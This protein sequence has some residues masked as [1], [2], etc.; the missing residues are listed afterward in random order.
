MTFTIGQTVTVSLDN[1]KSGLY[2]SYTDMANTLGLTK[3]TEGAAPKGYGT[4]VTATVSGQV[5]AVGKHPGCKDE[6]EKIICELLTGSAEHP[7]AGKDILGVEI[8]GA[9]FLYSGEDVITA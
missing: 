5:V 2:T 7:E 6:M 3:Y 9:Q 8:D 1:T 4:D